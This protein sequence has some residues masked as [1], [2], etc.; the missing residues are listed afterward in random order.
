M[1]GQRRL[2]LT[3]AT[4]PDL[5]FAA[6]AGE[7]RAKVRKRRAACEYFTLGGLD[8]GISVGGLYDK[9]PGVCRELRGMAYRA[10]LPV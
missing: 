3:A 7:V 8:T 9:R 1:P 2:V 10:G 4:S 5:V 6:P